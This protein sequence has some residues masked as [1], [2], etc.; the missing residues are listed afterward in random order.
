[1][2]YLS[3]CALLLGILFF[4]QNE[5]IAQK[6][7]MK[8]YAPV[9]AK[10]NELLKATFNTTFEKTADGRFVL[11]RYYIDT[12]VVIEEVFFRRQKIQGERRPFQIVVR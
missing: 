10:E 8:Y 1:M 9:V 2:N 3:S 12:K 7:W 5:S 11:H 4:G 6:K